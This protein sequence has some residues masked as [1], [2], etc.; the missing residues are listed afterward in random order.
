MPV[1]L[2]QPAGQRLLVERR[3]LP[4]RRR[5][6]PCAPASSKSRRGS[7]GWSLDELLGRRDAGRSSSDCHSAAISDSSSCSPRAATTLRRMRA[8]IVD[9]AAVLGDPGVDLGALG[10]AHEGEDVAVDRRRDERLERSS[11]VSYP[12]DVERRRPWPVR[13]RKWPAGPR[14]CDR[15][16]TARLWAEDDL[17]GAVPG[18][19]AHARRWPRPCG[20]P[21]SR[22][23][24]APAR[25]AQRGRGP[26]RA[27]P[28]GRPRCGPCP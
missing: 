22:G 1:R 17:L 9:G 23:R 15:A 24:G 4:A 16:G 3:W 6:R 7:P 27:A 13:S 18:D 11:S 14:W 19:L 26:P 28:R 25:R 8:G 21:R 20:R 10:V 2:T 12:G 5:R